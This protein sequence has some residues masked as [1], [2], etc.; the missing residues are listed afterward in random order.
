MNILKFSLSIAILFLTLQTG[1]LAQNGNLSDVFKTHMNETVQEVKNS[2][3][4]EDKREILD[5]SFNKMLKAVEKIENRATMSENELAQ[6]KTF[7]DAIEE[8]SN[9]LNGLDGYKKVADADLEDFSEYSQ[10]D[11]EQADKTLTISITTVLLVI[12]IL[13]LL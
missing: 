12:L 5:N 2:D 1:A 9:Q 3:S 8:K 6:L 10:Q 7:R 4:A 11:M 13:L